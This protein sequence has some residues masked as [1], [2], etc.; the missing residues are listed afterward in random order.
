[1]VLLN[2]ASEIF[3]ALG[4]IK[5]VCAITDSNYHAVWHWRKKGKFPAR[6]FK[7]INDVLRERGIEAPDQL[8]GM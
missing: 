6:T 7:D 8:W 3:E 4:G 2:S 5:A 1:M